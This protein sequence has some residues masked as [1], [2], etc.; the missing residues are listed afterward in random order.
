M[1]T[2]PPVEIPTS[3]ADHPYFTQIRIVHHP[4]PNGPPKIPI[5]YLNRPAKMNAFTARMAEELVVGFNLFARDDRVR[6]IILTG[7]GSR[8]FSAGADLGGDIISDPI[9]KEPGTHRDESAPLPGP[10]P[11]LPTR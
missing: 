5:V 1:P 7:T 9:P 3:Y 4:K 8:A 10:I 6:C 2:P 11:A